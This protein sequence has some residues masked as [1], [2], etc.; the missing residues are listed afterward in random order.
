MLWKKSL[1]E[2][3]PNIS[4]SVFQPLSITEKIPRAALERAA[5]PQVAVFITHG[6]G[7]QLPFETLDAA[8]E[9]LAHAAARYGQP[10][11]SIRARTVQIDGVKTQRAEFDMRDARGRDTEVHVYEGYWAP[12]TEGQVSLR[13][14]MWFLLGAGYSGIM[15]CRLPFERWIFG[16]EVMFGRQIG[17]ALKLLATL[18]VLLGLVALNAVIAVVGGSRVLQLDGA[19]K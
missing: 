15:N 4:R 14:V 6:M 19:V 13:D 8:V 10:V 18:G 3:S 1:K 7:Q 5:K 11:S 16:R 17:A 9:G 12:I 2:K